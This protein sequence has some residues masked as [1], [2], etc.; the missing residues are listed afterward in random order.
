MLYFFL[1]GIEYRRG[2]LIMTPSTGMPRIMNL[3]SKKPLCYHHSIVEQ[4]AVGTIIRSVI[5]LYS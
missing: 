2:N 1:V 3:T 4:S 5:S